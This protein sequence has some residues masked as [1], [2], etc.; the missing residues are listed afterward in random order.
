MRIAS[1]V[2]F[3]LLFTSLCVYAQ[4]NCKSA[5]ITATTGAGTYCPGDVVTLSITGELNDANEW[6]WSTG[7]C[8]GDVIDNETG[9][10][11]MV[12]VSETIT[13]FVRG[14]GGCAEKD[15]TCTEIEVVLDDE[16]PI[17]Q[18]PENITVSAE[19]GLCEAVVQYEFPSGS[20]N[21]D[22]EVTVEQVEG[23]GSD[24]S[25]PVGVTTESYELT[26]ALGNT[27]ICSFT[28]TVE[29]NEAPV[30][31]CSENIEVDNDPG[32]CGA[33][34]TYQLPTAT[35]NCENV[36]I[37]LT[38]GLGS[39]AFF[40]V[41]TTVETYTATDE[42]GNTSSCSISIT[43]IDA[44]LPVITLSKE[45]KSK[46]PPN[47]KHFTI[48]IEDYIESVTDNCPGVSIEDVI[49]DEVSSDEENNGSGDGN[50]T[51]DIMISSD[52]KTVEL[53]AERK[54]NG[55]GRIYTI[56]LAVKDAHGNIGTAVINAEVA[57]DQG[58][59]TT[60][61]DDG[62]VY[63]VNGCDIIVDEESISEGLDDSADP[64]ENSLD[65]PLKTYPNP[66]NGSLIIN[67]S[68]R[69]SDHIT[70]DLYSLSGLRVH[71]LF[72]GDLEANDV[73]FWNFNLEELD[74]KIYLLVI[75]GKKTFALRKLV[76]N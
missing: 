20:D 6:E 3:C 75:N 31:T 24:A 44:E 74:G 56:L 69:V 36:Q 38:G 34:V 37:E 15:A 12:E 62:P 60:V 35:D 29:D 72:E 5:E 64:S 41:G 1:L 55:N 61:T 23:L 46:W 28:I 13:Y 45:K 58:K 25:F 48:I 7:S 10:S 53:L 2:T 73:Y 63:V 16:P 51:D 67:F 70:M 21:C 68:P 14:V 71:R 18:C 65:G 50:T 39:G 33:V 52:C 76:K 26:D 4:D 22:G 54:G 30:I 42:A 40:P 27:S 32:E 57:H 49:I 11:I 9:T 19:P 66:F 43:V 8:G 17:T 47:H 59:N